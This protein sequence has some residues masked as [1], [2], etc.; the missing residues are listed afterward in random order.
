MM[1][2]QFLFHKIDKIYTR[3]KFRIPEIK[4]NFR[5]FSNNQKNNKKIK[6]IIVLLTI[7]VF[8]VI[9]QRAISPVF[10]N[11]CEDRAKSIATVVSN[12]QATEV[13]KDYSYNNIYEIEKDKEGNVTM[14][15][16]DIFVI[17][18]ITSDIAVRIQNKINEK[19]KDD[20]GIAL[21]TF[22]GSKLLSG[23][24]PNINI[25][26]STIG[27]VETDLKSEFQAQ[28]INQTL[29]RIYLQVKCEIII[30]T[31]FKNIRD[32]ITNQ[33]LLAENVIVG[34][35]PDTFYNFNGTNEENTALEVMN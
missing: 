4:T 18:E 5:G 19:G 33:V 3:H 11:L 23:R 29:H 30:L 1:K 6:A 9:I 28:G 22:T 20:I 31:P 7:I 25:R 32:T 13:M 10:Y 16:S 2:A 35:I 15:K 24:G 14:I 12:E 21:G 17:N 26:I 8:I 27:N 34:N